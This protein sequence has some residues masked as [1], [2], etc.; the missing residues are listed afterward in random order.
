L[1]GLKAFAHLW[2]HLALEVDIHQS[3]CVQFSFQSSFVDKILHTM[4]KKTNG[5]TRFVKSYIYN[6]NFYKFWSLDAL[7]QNMTHMSTSMV[8]FVLCDYV[9]HDCSH[10]THIQCCILIDL[11]YLINY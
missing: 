3:P 11:G 2:K 6:S 9:L 8:G 7:C 10:K 5:P 4:G 1:K